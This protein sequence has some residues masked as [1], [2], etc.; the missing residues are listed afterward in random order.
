MAT[1]EFISHSPHRAEVN[2][3]A[4]KWVQ[5]QRRNCFS[6]LPQ[7][8]WRDETPWRE[9]NLWALQKAENRK[10]RPTT[11]TTFMRHITAY[12]KWLEAEGIDWWHFPARESDRC[13]VRYRGSLINAIDS[14]QL[15]SSTAQQRMGAVIRFYKWLM[16]TKLLSPEWPAWQDRHIGIKIVDRFGLERSMGV[17]STDLS[18]P[19]RRADTSSLEEGLTPVLTA[20]VVKILK[21]SNEHASEELDLLL[22][23]GFGTGMRIGTLTDLKVDTVLNAVSAFNFP[24]FHCLSV[25]PGAQ[26]PVATKFGVTGQILISDEDLRLL[27]SYISS[28]RRLL[29]QAKANAENRNLVFLTRHGTSY[30]A[31]DGNASRTVNVELGRLRKAGLREGINAFH[32]FYFHRSRCTF[33]TELARAACKALPLSDAIQLVKASMLHKDEATTIK[34]IKFI[35]QSA[36]MAELAN[37]FTRRFLGLGRQ[38]DEA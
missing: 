20:D 32:K 21:F 9:A 4:V 26:P 6:N 38:Q 13:L 23:L 24:G 16:A 37:E 34:Y 14:G 25:G 19:N 11:I 27:K 1:L 29:R 15:V 36:D 7:I 3:G 31:S 33:A 35:E 2:D 30:V 17:N 5:A 22:R 10:T 8:C 28:R 18:I 12:A